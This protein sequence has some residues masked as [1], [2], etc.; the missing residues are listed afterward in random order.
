[1]LVVGGAS[2]DTLD[3]S[4]QLI[5]GG[6]GMYTAM[7]ACRSGATVTLYAPRPQPMP[8]ALQAVDASLT[9]LGPTIA[10]EQLAH[11]EISYRN[12]RTTYVEAFFGAEDS[13]APDGLPDDLSGF[14]IVH[15][16]PLGDIGRQ[17]AFLL[18]CRARGARVVS[19]G[20][21]LHLIAAQPDEAAAVL[22][23]ADIFFMN[24]AEAM[25]LFGSVDAV[26]SR[27]GQVF[28]VTRGQRGATVVQGNWRTEVAGVAAAVLDPT[29]AGDS[30][31]G[32]TLVAL[33]A[34]LHPVMAAR[35]AMP[36]AAELT[37]A[38]GPVALLR[39]APPPPE[40]ADQRVVVHAAQLQ[41]IAALIAGL[42]DIS[43]YA[44]VGP[45]LP[46]P[47]HPAALDYFF[48]ATLQQYGFWSAIDGRYGEPL[49]AR[50]AGEERKGAFY[51]F[52]AW[53]R[54][55]ENDPERLSPAAQARLTATEL[56]TLLRADDGT[57]P[58]PAIDTHLALARAYGRDMLALGLTPQSALQTINQSARPLRTLMQLLDHIGGYKEDPLRK[59]AGL[60]AIILRQRPEAFLAGAA[61][62]VPPVVDYH[63]MRSCLRIGLIE[64]VDAA[65]AARL[66]ARELLPE[67]DEWAVRSAAYHAMQELVRRSGKSMGA[68]DWFFFQARERCPEMTAPRCAECAVD[69]LCAHRK[70]LF[71][72]VRRTTFY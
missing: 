66:V 65:L 52:R 22:H 45:D 41:R 71:Q 23:A 34:G 28:F 37:E 46:P 68:V 5:A 31:C 4:E 50:V 35:R 3:G 60:L 51:L 67:A 49:L 38:L 16:V 8:D 44:F 18:A 63:V 62:D 21:A 32:A 54:W 55:L 9:W 64:V 39:A 20:T 24:E 61:D 42:D 70:E 27:A 57:E 40:R 48:S 29:G 2:L 30:F 56:R 53:L 6:A 11:F 7:A 69:P 47:D 58:M 19:A 33:A 15:L 13:L 26:Q 12:G 36:L 72:A 59:K 17:H 14:D 43:P 1:M 10:A 25:R